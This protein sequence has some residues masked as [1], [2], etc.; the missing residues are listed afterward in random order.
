MFLVN[1]N[2]M[3]ESTD[4]I[5]ELLGHK[6]SEA[7]KHVNGGS[8]GQTLLINKF[9]KELKIRGWRMPCDIPNVDGFILSKCIYF[10][11]QVIEKELIIVERNEKGL[12]YIPNFEYLLCWR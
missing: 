11:D 10:T 5:L 7:K 9:E 12:H 2:I 3:L 8:L 6:I 4:R 1:V